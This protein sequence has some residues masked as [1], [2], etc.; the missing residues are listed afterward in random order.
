MVFC[1]IN[2]LL[3]IL[4]TLY[5]II[6]H[7]RSSIVCDC[8]LKCIATGQP[9]KLCLMLFIDDISMI[10]T[11]GSEEL[12]QLTTRANSTHSSIKFTT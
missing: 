1:S 8:S 6:M 2:F 3:S 9:E 10:W 4:G 11:H 12:E 5:F 7:Q